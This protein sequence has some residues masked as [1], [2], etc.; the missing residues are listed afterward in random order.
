MDLINTIANIFLPK[1]NEYYK[2]VPSM[3]EGGNIDRSD[4]VLVRKILK[5]CINVNN[6]LINLLF[7]NIDEKDDDIRQLVERAAQMGQLDTVKFFVEKKNYDV[8]GYHDAVMINAI[9]HGHYDLV[10]Y[11]VEREPEY[12][13][14]Q[15]MILIIAINNNDIP[16]VQYLYN[17]ACAQNKSYPLELLNKAFLHCAHNGDVFLCR[18]FME[19]GVDV[20]MMDGMP[21]IIS[22]QAGHVDMVKLLVGNGADPNVGDGTALHYALSNNHH[23]VAE[24]LCG[25]VKKEIRDRLVKQYTERICHRLTPNLSQASK[26]S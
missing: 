2:P 22:A 9:L 6:P 1:I 24:Y 5:K 21:L 13:P 20:N 4:D 17:N 18:F 3:R 8:H 16:I 25:H 12:Y 7:K 19:Q 11:L 23:E 10:C 26:S 15:H 14:D